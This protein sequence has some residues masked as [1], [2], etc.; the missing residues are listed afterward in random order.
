[1]ERARMALAEFQEGLKSRPN[2]ADLHY[3]VAEIQRLEGALPEARESIRKVFSLNPMGLAPE[4]GPWT[5][6]RWLREWEV[7]RKEVDEYI[8]RH[9]D[10]LE[11]Y[12]DKARIL[13]NGFG[14]LEGARAVL[15]DGMKLPLNQGRDRRLA[16]HNQ[17]FLEGELL[18]EG[19]YQ[20]A[21][22]CLAAQPGDDITAHW[23]RWMRKGMTYVA[24]NQ[25][26][27]AM[28]CFDTALSYCRTTSVRS[29]GS[30]I[31]L[32]SRWHGVGI[33]R[34]RRWSLRK[35]ARLDLW[36]PQRKELEE[37]QA[38]AA[39]LAGD[40]DRALSL[41][42]QL[43]PKPGYLTVWDLRLDPVYN[44]LRSNPRFQALL[45]KGERIASPQ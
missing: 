38:Q 7:A 36:W 2:W 19:K 5:V 4:W 41:L 29:I 26:A 43:I 32:E 34:R 14:D 40:T 1:M 30:I 42:E 23:T 45:A 33:M 10:D 27:T 35:P 21:L 15:E 17:R 9:P 31:G 37:A 3:G 44:P 28:A 12:S 16:Y 24:L 13:I 8:S 11:G 18:S 6:S 39:V 22:A 25:R 20:E